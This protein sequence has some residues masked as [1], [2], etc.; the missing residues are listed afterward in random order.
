[1]YACLLFADPGYVVTNVAR[2]SSL[3]SFYF[4]PKYRWDYPIVVCA[5]MESFSKYDIY[6]LMSQ[7]VMKRIALGLSR[8]SVVTWLILPVVI[9]LSQRLTHA[10]VSIVV[11]GETANG[12]LKQL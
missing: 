5:A 7:S 11:Y 2:Y 8:S 9:C 10:C 3:L 6:T 12:S 1:M 4:C